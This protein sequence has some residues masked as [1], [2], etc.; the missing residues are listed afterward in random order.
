[1]IGPFKVLYFYNIS[2]WSP[3]DM[4][5]CW[6]LVSQTWIKIYTVWPLRLQPCWIKCILAG[7]SSKGYSILSPFDLFQGTCLELQLFLNSISAHAT[8]TPYRSRQCGPATSHGDGSFL[9]GEGRSLRNSCYR[10]VWLGS[11]TDI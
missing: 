5:A 8:V 10:L 7:K 3:V 2:I 9:K 1:M 6:P 4:Y 11:C